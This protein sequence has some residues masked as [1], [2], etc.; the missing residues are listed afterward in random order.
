MSIQSTELGDDEVLVV[1][2]RRAQHLLDVGH[3]RLY[4]LIAARE[5]ESYCE[6]R[7]RKITLRS[8]KQYI[9]R[10]LGKPEAA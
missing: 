9:E 3:T 6:G 1:S 10:Q 7:S 5:L 4:Q 2:P 8:I